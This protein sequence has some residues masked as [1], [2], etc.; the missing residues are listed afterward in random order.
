MTRVVDIV[1]RTLA[2]P[3]IADMRVDLSRLPA[4][5]AEHFPDSG[6]KPWLDRDD[7]PRNIETLPKEEATICGHWARDG[8]VVLPKLIPESLLDHAWRAYEQAVKHGA[9]A[10]PREPV[11]EE[12]R[13]P[14]RYLNPHK[15]VR[16]L[17]RVAKFRPLM[18][19]LHR[20]L[21]YPAKLL[22]TI[23]S[24]KGSQQSAHSDSI[25]MTTYPLGYLAAAWIAFEDI[26]ADSGPLEFIHKAT[27][28]RM[29]SRT[30]CRSRSTTCRTRVMLPIGRAMSHSYMS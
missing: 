1:L 14:G 21:G 6:P 20:L 22:Q 30:I 16:S 25:H 11:G 26:H 29:C 24:H 13:L 12:D 10:L 5:R 19:W 3:S 15:R 2:P 27:V 9:I 23:A 28:C 17:C 8:Y 4:Y 18:H 7:W